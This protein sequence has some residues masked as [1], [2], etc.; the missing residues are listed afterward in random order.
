MTSK[1]AIRNAVEN[2]LDYL[3]GA[4]IAIHRNS[5]IIDSN[6]MS[7]H[8][9]QPGTEFLIGRNSANLA[10][11]RYWVDIGA[12]SAVLYD[13]ALLQITYDF[14][15]RGDELIGHRLAYVPCPY[16]VDQEMLRELP[17]LDVVDM[18]AETEPTSMNLHT[19]IRFDFDPHSS[20]A[21]HPASHLT[22]NS[23]DCRIAC[24]APM[25]F[26]R[27]VDFVFRCFYPAMWKAH[28]VFFESGAI[29]NLGPRTVTDDELRQPHI[30]WS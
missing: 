24:C 1:R 12:F 17:I 28:S 22:I 23:S 30:A 20:K 10:A 2:T 3:I 27:F 4:E 15:T 11:Y 5:A 9:V 29:K 6:K 18:Y 25:H 26:S 13:G 19:A 14:G 8:F 7:W 21:G 16:S